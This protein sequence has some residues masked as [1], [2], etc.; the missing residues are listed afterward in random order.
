MQYIKTFTKREKEILELISEGLSSKLIAKKLGIAENTVKV[1][2]KNILRKADASK[3]TKV[4]K[5]FVQNDN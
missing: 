1:H 5:A 2:R 4:I 3:M